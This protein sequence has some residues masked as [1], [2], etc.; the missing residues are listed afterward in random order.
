MADKLRLP[1]CAPRRRRGLQGSAR[2]AQGGS[3]PPQNMSALL[4]LC[5]ELQLPRVGAGSA[6]PLRDSSLSRAVT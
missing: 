3:R 1:A 5:V 4:E 6:A 2:A